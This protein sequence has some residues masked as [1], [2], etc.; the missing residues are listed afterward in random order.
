MPFSK[1]WENLFSQGKHFSKYPWSH[2]IGLVTRFADPKDFN[3]PLK[4]LE[5]GC[6]MGTN[7]PFF[8]DRGFEYYAIEGSHTAVSYVEKR[9]GKLVKICCHDFSEGIPCETEFFD[10]VVDRSSTTH[11][12]IDDI[13]RVIDNVRRVL[14]KDSLFIVLDWFSTESYGF[15]LGQKFESRSITNC[16]K[17]YL[18]GCGVAHFFDENELRDLFEGWQF[19][20]LVK[21]ISVPYRTKGESFEKNLD[22]AEGAWDF[23][24]KNI[25]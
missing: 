12:C 2:L 24:V 19:L 11:N 17:G 1:E 13:K 5:L 20:Y 4:V 23:V 10:L 18:A 15:R 7:I 3:Y 9:F 22:I 6:G 14:K 8:L 25:K 16:E 21:K